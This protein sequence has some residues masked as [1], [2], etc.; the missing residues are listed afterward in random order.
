MI[1]GGQH[2]LRK[3]SSCKNNLLGIY[4]RITN[5]LEKDGWMN[6]RFLNCQK[7]FD[8]VPTKDSDTLHFRTTIQLGVEMIL[9]FQKLTNYCIIFFFHSITQAT[10]LTSK[11]GSRPPTI[12]NILVQF[13]LLN[14]YYTSPYLSSV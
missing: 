13:F 5:I 3:K 9:V 2:I 11:E 7:A 6:C 8:Y 4:E 12:G 1:R 14:L 10:C